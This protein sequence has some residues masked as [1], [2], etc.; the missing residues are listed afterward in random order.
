MLNRLAFAS[1]SSQAFTSSASVITME[2]GEGGAGH[3]SAIDW[4]LSILLLMLKLCACTISCAELR[5][6]SALSLFALPFLASEQK[7]H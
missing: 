5:G 7:C 4:N 2:Q 1:D 6:L 3:V